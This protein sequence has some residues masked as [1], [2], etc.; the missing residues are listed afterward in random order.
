MPNKREVPISLWVVGGVACLVA[1]A[2][3]WYS[4]AEDAQRAERGRQLFEG[5][6][7]MVARLYGQATFLPSMASRCSNC[8]AGQPVV[9]LGTQAFGPRLNRATL[10]ALAARRGGPPSRFTEESFCRLLSDGMDP[11]SIMLAGAM[12]R[13]TLAPADCQALWQYL[14]QAPP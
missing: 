2:T 1:L 14:M 13:Y 8:H 10:T 6:Q 12:P 4:R 7:P 11:A 3:A 5:S 9:A